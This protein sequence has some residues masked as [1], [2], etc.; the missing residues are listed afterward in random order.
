MSN[1]RKCP[2]CIQSASEAYR[3]GYNDAM[4]LFQAE[5]IK[6]Q[7]LRPIQ[8]IVPENS[9]QQQLYVEDKSSTLPNGNVI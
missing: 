6:A 4:G 1:I 2:N 9:V 8:I 7:Q 5:M 3:Q